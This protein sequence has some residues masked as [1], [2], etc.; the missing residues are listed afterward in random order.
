MNFSQAIA[1]PAISSG[2]YGFPLD[3]CAHTLVDAAVTFCKK[4]SLSELQEINFVVFKPSDA[5]AFVK[6]LEAQFPQDDIFISSQG[7]STYPQC[8][9]NPGVKTATRKKTKKAV[10]THQDGIILK[11]GSLTDVKVYCVGYV[12]DLCTCSFLVGQLYFL[13][14]QKSK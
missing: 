4:N 6:A 14:Y 2:I 5:Q 13:D 12:V 11:Q 3:R 7:K 1:F 8:A 9:P 10:A